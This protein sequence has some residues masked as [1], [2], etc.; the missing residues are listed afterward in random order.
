M[1]EA[2]GPVLGVDGGATKT[3]AIV[4]A[5]DGRCSA[6]A[7]PAARTGRASAS[8]MRC[9]P[10][11]A[12]ELRARGRRAPARR[13]QGRGLRAGR[14]RLARRSR[15]S[16]RHVSPSGWAGRASSRTTPSR[17][18]APASPAPPDAS[19]RRARGRS[20][21]AATRRGRPLA[22][23]PR[24]SASWAARVTSSSAPL[25]ACARMREASGP[26]TALAETF[27]D[28][29]RRA[30][31]R[32][33][34]RVHQARG[35]V[36]GADLAPLVLE[37][38]ASG[39]EV[40]TAARGAGTLAGGRGHGRRAPAG[41]ARHVLR[42]RDRRQRA[43]RRLAR[44]WTRRSRRAWRRTRRARGSFHCASAPSSAPAGSRST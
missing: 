10:R 7:A 23:W 28:G 30:R 26:E 13:D 6:A 27:C 39:D 12:V 16:R 25:W 33:P 9:N 24:A 38:A 35:L 40:P 44:R 42:A 36:L 29:A 5:A 22:R 43:P 19:R 1:A 32:R 20:Q 17:R 14:R 41:H 3:D 11:L 34:L 8:T 37:V 31:P 2:Q 15:A 21:P 4:M 18:C